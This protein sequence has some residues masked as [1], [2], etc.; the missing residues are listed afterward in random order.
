MWPF[1][2]TCWLLQGMPPIPLQE[3]ATLHYVKYKHIC[4]NINSDS[5]HTLPKVACIVLVDLKQLIHM[6][7]MIIHQLLTFP[8]SC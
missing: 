4:S 5:K 3:F 8:R 1:S 6:V 7:D 2:R